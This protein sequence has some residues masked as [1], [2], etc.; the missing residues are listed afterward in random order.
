MD[1][2]LHTEMLSMVMY[3]NENINIW[4]N[5][6]KYIWLEKYIKNKLLN[7]EHDIYKSF[8][9]EYLVNFK[10]RCKH[11][12]NDYCKNPIS[13]HKLQLCSNHTHIRMH[14][15]NILLNINS[16]KA[17]SL[18]HIIIDYLY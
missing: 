16:I 7:G 18:I 4:L 8:A 14:T 12:L 17:Q 15:Y 1:K 13:N 11:T 9:N 2:N 10:W 5:K 6:P 3:L